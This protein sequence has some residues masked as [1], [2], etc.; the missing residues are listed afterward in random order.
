M[1]KAIHFIPKI[2]TKNIFV[3]HNG[4]IIFRLFVRKNVFIVYLLQIRA[5]IFI[6]CQRAP[7]Q[8]LHISVR[9]SDIISIRHYFLFPLLLLVFHSWLNTAFQ[10]AIGLIPSQSRVFRETSF[11][12][13]SIFQT[14]R[15]VKATAYTV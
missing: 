1:R 15:T 13:N 8:F 5:M 14:I 6:K 3:P 7:E 12:Q 10:F 11:Q 4:P 2:S 9:V